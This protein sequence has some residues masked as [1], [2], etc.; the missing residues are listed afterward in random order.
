MY[1]NICLSIILLLGCVGAKAQDEVITDTT[2]MGFKLFSEIPYYRVN[3]TYKS[4][5]PDGET[6]ITLSAAMVF[7]DKVFNR[8]DTVTVGGQEYNASGLMLCNHYT[9]TEQSEAP[10][11]T[12]KMQIEGPLAAMGL[13]SIIISPDGY[14]FGS[15]VDKPQTYLMADIT[16]RHNIDAVRAAR[17]L[18]ASMDYTYGDLFTQ[19]GYSQGGHTTMA[20]QRYFDTHD[21]DPEAIA[22]I[23]YTLCGDGPYDMDAMLDTLLIPEARFRYPVA[24]PL[25]IQGLVEGTQLDITY[26]DCLREPFDTKAVEWLNAKTY[27]TDDIND[28][29]FKITGANSRTGVLAA[30]V[31]RTENMSRSD[32]EAQPFFQA[33]KENSFVSD[34]QPNEATRFYLYHSKDDEIVPYF[35]ME[36]MAA[37]L[38]DE[39]GVGDDRLKVYE[40]SGTHLA[41]ATLFVLNALAE[42]VQLESR[43][44]EG[45]YT[46]TSIH[47]LIA[48]D[49]TTAKP[50]TGW[51]NLQGQR[52]SGRP[53]VPGL[54]IHDG[55]KVM[56]RGSR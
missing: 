17:R 43:Y 46:P 4:V 26:S 36:H 38:R 53:S 35:C 30:D 29:I 33:I 11:Q 39:C 42:L 20:V 14:G 3:Y 31:I 19:I 40:S 50:I 56:V 21:V 51:Y 45:S 49:V 44:L 52:L 48:S 24:L 2:K 32:S 23:D 10:T 1:R 9:M 22:G 6:P 34:W 41:A 7:P 5:A 47:G 27:T 37:Y 8:K 16:A 13:K 18:L 54:Y 15:T 25:I 55:K 28:S 12:S